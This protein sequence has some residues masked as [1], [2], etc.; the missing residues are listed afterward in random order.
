MTLKRGDVV[1]VEFP[2]SSGSVSKLRPALVVQTNRNN[3]RLT[4]DVAQHLAELPIDTATQAR[5]DELA[6]K[7]TEGELSEV[8]R[9]EYETYV[10]A[11]DFLAVLQAQARQVLDR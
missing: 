4:R 5:L 9:A 2:F 1:L 8:E 10:H 3:R 6:E 11:L 7:S